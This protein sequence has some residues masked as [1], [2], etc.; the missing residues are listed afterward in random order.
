MIVCIQRR[1]LNVTVTLVTF[2]LLLQGLLEVADAVIRMS[3]NHPNKALFPSAGQP[4]LPWP[5]EVIV[6]EHVDDLFTV[7]D[8]CI[9]FI[10]Q[11]PLDPNNCFFLSN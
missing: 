6:R 2:L 1:N 8:F 11:V 5:E 10:V 9:P 4:F 7:S 3:P